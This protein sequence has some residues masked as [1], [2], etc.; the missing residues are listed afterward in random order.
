MS[1]AA[2]A[3]NG[4]L[5]ALAADPD[6]ISRCQT[7]KT[8]SPSR[9]LV[10]AFGSVLHGCK[11]CRRERYIV[12]DHNGDFWF[13]DLGKVFTCVAATPRAWATLLI[14]SPVSSSRATA[15]ALNSAVY[16]LR[17]FF[18]MTFLQM[19]L[20]FTTRSSLVGHGHH[21][22]GGVTGLQGRLPPANPFIKVS[23]HQHPVAVLWGGITR[24]GRVLLV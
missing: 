24:N 13:T 22:K 16:R 20:Q 11:A 17:V 9:F 12:F 15:A 3:R 6:A 5:P 8:C 7:S 19:V 4:M 21:E 1:A 23:L 14:I 18:V 2:P 10:S